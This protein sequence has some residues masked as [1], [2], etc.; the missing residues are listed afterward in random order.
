VRPFRSIAN[1]DALALA[2]QTPASPIL[3]DPLGDGK[4]L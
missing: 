2:E 4:E 3:G 1:R